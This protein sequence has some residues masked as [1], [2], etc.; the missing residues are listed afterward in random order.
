MVEDQRELREVLLRQLAEHGYAVDACE[1][2]YAGKDYLEAADYDLA[3]LDIGL[4][5]MSGMELLAWIRGREMYVQVLML[6]R[7]KNQNKTNIYTLADLI[8][9]NSAGV[10]LHSGQE[11][12]LDERHRQKLPHTVRGRG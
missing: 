12:S 11:I 5:G 6:T 4:P 10:C 3:I 7:K 2:A 1:N 9:G 8:L